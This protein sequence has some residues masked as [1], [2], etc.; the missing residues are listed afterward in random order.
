[1]T[2]GLSDERP[3][4]EEQLKGMINAEKPLM[5]YCAKVS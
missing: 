2:A 4:R 1:V 3:G 5:D